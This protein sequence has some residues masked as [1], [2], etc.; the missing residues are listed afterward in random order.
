MSLYLLAKAGIQLFLN[1][2]WVWV[3]R[4]RSP[5]CCREA[6]GVGTSLNEQNH[7]WKSVAHVLLTS[8]CPCVW[9]VQGLGLEMLRKLQ[10]SLG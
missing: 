8:I 9:W 10:L 5:R 1:N 6:V 7:S 3:M 4:E 2:Q